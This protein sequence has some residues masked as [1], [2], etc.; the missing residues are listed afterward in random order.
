M[1]ED[2][3]DRIKAKS[4]EDEDRN[5]LIAHHELLKSR[6]AIQNNVI[7]KRKVGRFF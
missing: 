3:N 4:E 5:N 7:T 6:M 2:E 1:G